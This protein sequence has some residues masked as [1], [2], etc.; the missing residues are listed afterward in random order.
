ME[1]VVLVDEDDNKKELK[2]KIK[3]HKDGDLHRAF[4]V[5]I[6]NKRE[7]LLLQQRAEEKYHSGSL[8]SNSCCSHPRDKKNILKEGKI[9]LNE[10]LGLESP[11]LSH[12]FSFR[13]KAELEN[14]ITEHELD[15]VLAG[16]K[17]NFEFDLDPKEVKDYQWKKLN[18]INDEIKSQPN[19]FTSWFKIIMNNYENHLKKYLSDL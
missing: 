3:A 12:L 1:K 15:H 18:E 13:Y 7:E 19:K 16:T 8:W 11:E 6:F 2:E 17:S 14:E 4:S 10:E 9:R 5:F